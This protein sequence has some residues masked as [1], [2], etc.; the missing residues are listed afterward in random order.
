MTPVF[1][2]CSSN[3]WPCCFLNC[4]SLWQQL[5]TL[6]MSR[7]LQ[8][9]LCGLVK[10]TNVFSRKKNEGQIRRSLDMTL[11]NISLLLLAHSI[12]V[13]GKFAS[14]W[15]ILGSLKWIWLLALKLQWLFSYFAQAMC[16]FQEQGEVT[17]YW[18][19]QQKGG[20]IFPASLF[21][22]GDKLTNRDHCKWHWRLITPG[23][24]E[25]ECIIHSHMCMHTL[26][27]YYKILLIK[28]VSF[29][30]ST[31]LCFGLYTR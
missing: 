25:F 24:I 14:I 10:C 7:A 20:G 9:S 3:S 17:H 16:W 21:W 27:L 11:L 26:V 6:Q 12:L 15:P 18:T 1:L 22:K 13:P 31:A 23:V 29:I 4:L 19:S 28:G 2:W 5:A 8:Q 30:V